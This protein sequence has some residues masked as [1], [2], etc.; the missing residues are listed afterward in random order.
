[1]KKWCVPAS[2]DLWV[3]VNADDEEQARDIVK[4]ITF[5]LVDKNTENKKYESRFGDCA[6]DV[7]EAIDIEEEEKTLPKPQSIKDVFIND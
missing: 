5:D 3:W 6:E 1:M 2:I 7:C 4:S